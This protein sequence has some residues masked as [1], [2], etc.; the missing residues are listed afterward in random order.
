MRKLRD[1]EMERLG[2]EG[3]RRLAEELVATPTKV[4]EGK[5]CRE[6]VTLLITQYS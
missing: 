5:D 4:N 3:T 6:H 1:G 2:D